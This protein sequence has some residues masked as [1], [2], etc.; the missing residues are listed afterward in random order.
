MGIALGGYLINNENRLPPSSCHENDPEK[1]WL[2]ALAK[3]TKQPLLFRCPSDKSK[4]PFVDWTQPLAKQLS[5]H[6]EGMRYSSYALN[7]L[8]DP[9]VYDVPGNNGQFNNV[10]TIPHPQSCIWILE[11]PQEWTGEDHPHPEYWF[12]NIE[13]AKK[14]VA[15]QRHINKSNYMFI[16]LHVESMEIEETY[17][18]DDQ[19]LWFPESAPTWPDWTRQSPF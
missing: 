3:H 4:L 16:D 14:F 8:L 11:A 5:S 19:C 7:N 17:D 1:Y 15:W 2:C 9:I 12:G 18:L 13:T 6:P 10:L